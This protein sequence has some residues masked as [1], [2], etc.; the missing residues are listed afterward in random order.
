MVY[1]SLKS[2]LKYRSITKDEENVMQSIKAYL[3]QKGDK[4][5]FKTKAFKDLTNILSQVNFEVKKILH[6][7]LQMM[8]LIK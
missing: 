4:T 2:Y 5:T 8:K 7:Q 3:L 1:Y 6:L